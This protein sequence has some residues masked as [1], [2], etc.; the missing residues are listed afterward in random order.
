M[1]KFSQVVNFHAWESSLTMRSSERSRLSLPLQ[2]LEELIQRL[3]SKYFNTVYI[4]L[5]QEAGI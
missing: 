3:T 1:N 4:G 5:E 2:E